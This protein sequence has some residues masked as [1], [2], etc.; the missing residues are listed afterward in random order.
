MASLLAGRMQT[1]K[2]NDSGRQRPFDRASLEQA[3]GRFDPV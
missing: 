3:V 1:V 2:R